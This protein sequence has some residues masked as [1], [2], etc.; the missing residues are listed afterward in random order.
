[1][2][3]QGLTPGQILAQLFAGVDFRI[4]EETPLRFNCPCSP[5]QIEE[6]LIGLGQDE[7][8]R[9][10]EEQPQVE[11]TCEYCREVYRFSRERVQQLI[12]GGQ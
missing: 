4:Q 7:L 12:D 2:L 3:R 10:A 9:L 1:M 5:Q 11:V 6:V 8:Q